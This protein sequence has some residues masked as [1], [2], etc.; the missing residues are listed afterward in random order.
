[1]TL[2]QT[3][4]SED[5]KSHID[6]AVDLS[7]DLQTRGQ[8]NALSASITGNWGPA[9]AAARDPA[10]K[11]PQNFRDALI[12]T[13]QAL[14]TRDPAAKAAAAVQLAAL[15]A[16]MGGQFKIDLLAALGAYSAALASVEAQSD[17]HPGIRAAL[18]SP[19]MAPARADPAFPALIQRLHL[20]DYWR[21][22][23]TRPDFCA[24]K[25]AP[26]FCKSI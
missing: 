17:D 11:F 9:L 10:Q 12:A 16:T 18:Y 4:H 6:A 2:L 26:S 20:I 21:K 7:G 13:Y 5:A 22:S 14:L 15:P 1:M 3:G 8:M 23:R 25:E 24:V 19:M